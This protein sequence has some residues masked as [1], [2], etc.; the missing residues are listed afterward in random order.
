MIDRTCMGKQ[1]DARTVRVKAAAETTGLDI[2]MRLRRIEGTTFSISGGGAEYR[3]K[4]GRGEWLGTDQHDPN[5]DDDNLR[6]V[7]KAIM[8]S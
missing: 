4:E 1:A 8:Q 7:R 3:W 5:G 2:G 6:E